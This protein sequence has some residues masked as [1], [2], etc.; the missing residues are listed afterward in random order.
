MTSTFTILLFIALAFL[1][2]VLFVIVFVLM[3][4]RRMINH[5]E[6]LKVIDDNQ[7]EELLKASVSA[8]EKER[9]RVG[10]NL[11][12]DIA[13]N[14][15]VIKLGINNLIDKKTGRL[16]EE[17]LKVL[18]K[19]IDETIE[20]MRGISKELVPAV[21]NEF[22]LKSAIGE[23][24]HRIEQNS[25]IRVH[26]KLDDLERMDQK[27]ELELYR[28]IQELANN[29][30]KH[31]KATLFTVEYDKN[32]QN[33]KFRV[34]DNGSG[35]NLNGSGLDGKMGIGLKNL[36]ARASLIGA[37]MKIQSEENKGT[38]TEITFK[39]TII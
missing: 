21:L 7:K 6:Q 25:E 33:Q 9:S 4:Q 16:K 19:Q 27:V 20:L 38:R 2:I 30:M 35:F 31:S 28:M 13:P 15:S 26:L 14:L 37:E 5:H 32:A 17:N 12:D 11:H 8:Q 34:S 18:K 29:C 24:C 36:K 3:Y 39:E 22:G 10:A 1:L 23:L